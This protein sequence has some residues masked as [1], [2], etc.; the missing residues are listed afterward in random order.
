MYI[1]IYTYI[2]ICIYIYIYLRVYRYT[3]THGNPYGQVLNQEIA[4]AMAPTIEGMLLECQRNNET[5]QGQYVGLILNAYSRAGITL[6][7]TLPH[8]NTLRHTTPHCA[9]LRHTAPHCITLHHTAPHGNTLQQHRFHGEEGATAVTPDDIR[10]AST[11]I[12]SLVTSVQ[13]L[14]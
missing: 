10:V 12:G 11:W 5:L 2:Y 9:T 13:K 1:Y 7:H 4:G 6:H 14:F 8:C 3:H